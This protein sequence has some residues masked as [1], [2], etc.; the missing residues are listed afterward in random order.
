M[1]TR[2]S[3]MPSHEWSYSSLLKYEKCPFTRALRLQ[4][5]EAGEAG[6]AARKG[7]DIHAAIEEAL[8]AND[9]SAVKMKHPRHEEIIYA[10]CDHADKQIE[11]EW[12]VDADWMPIDPGTDSWGL[13]FA[14]AVAFYRSDETSSVWIIDWKTGKR[15]GN[16]LK[17]TGQM[18]CYAAFCAALNPEIDVFKVQL[19]YLNEKR[20]A[21]IVWNRQNAAFFQSRFTKRV[22]RMLNDTQLRPRPNRTNCRWCEY[23]SVNGSGVC[24]YAVGE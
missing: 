20:D 18:Q 4:G 14:D 11:A 17:H 21:T 24:P 7:K 16:E 9:P 13:A 10:L 22:E 8:L 15:R 1:P 6:E 23:G 19:C 2:N 5:A 3:E 12:R